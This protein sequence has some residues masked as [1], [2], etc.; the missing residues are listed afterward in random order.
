[1]LEIGI[2]TLQAERGYRESLTRVAGLEYPRE[3]QVAILPHEA[4]DIASIRY[5]VR[6]SSLLELGGVLS[7]N[8]FTDRFAAVPVALVVLI[9]IYESNFDA[10][11]EQVAELSETVA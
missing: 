2:S 6:I 4:T 5:N 10:T 7:G 9:S 1:V 8:G 11:V 3:A